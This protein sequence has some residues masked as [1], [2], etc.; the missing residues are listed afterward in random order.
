LESSCITI[1]IPFSQFSS[2]TFES[3]FLKFDLFSSSLQS[4]A[5]WFHFSPG[6]WKNFLS[7][8]LVSTF[9]TWQ[10]LIHR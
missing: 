10:S 7:N 3:I 4:W 5:N 8:P 9:A 2:K 1:T 6:Q